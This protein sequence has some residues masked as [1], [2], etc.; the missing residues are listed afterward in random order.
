MVPE[1]GDD[2]HQVVLQGSRVPLRRRGRQKSAP[3]GVGPRRMAGGDGARKPGA[4]PFR[5]RL[6]RTGPPP[7]R[8]RCRPTARR[9]SDPPGTRQHRS[10]GRGVRRPKPGPPPRDGARRSATR[11]ATT[12]PAQAVPSGPGWDHGQMETGG[13]KTDDVVVRGLAEQ[14]MIRLID[15]AVALRSDL[16]RHE[17]VCRS[18]LEGI[19]AG[20]PLGPVLE[21][22]GSDQWR[23]R[24]TESLSLYEGSATGRG[25]RLIAVG[26]AEGMTS[27]RY[28][29]SL[30]DHPSAGEPGHPR[31]RRA[32][33]TRG[34]LGRRVHRST[35][36]GRGG[37]TR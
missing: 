36:S 37:V 35:G 4:R 7:H 27:R 1:G 23:P 11:V 33:L 22:A 30:G 28:P 14:E 18:I 12:G 34:T 13:D 17:A 21:S 6:C 19:R 3:S 29:A 8:R 15:A 32:G 25:L 20:D 24:L 9:A 5:R 16:E 31:A 2:V 10:A 26:R